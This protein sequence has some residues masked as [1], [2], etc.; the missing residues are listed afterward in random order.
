[1]SRTETSELSSVC[2][3]P[4]KA[5][6]RKG[7]LTPFI[8]FPHQTLRC[9]IKRDGAGVKWTCKKCPSVGSCQMNHRVAGFS[10][11]RLCTSNLLWEAILILLQLAVGVSNKNEPSK[12]IMKWLPT[13]ILSTRVYC[14]EEL[15]T[16]SS[17]IFWFFIS[18][19]RSYSS[20]TA[21]PSILREKYMR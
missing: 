10:W 1:M 9:Y 12:S 19:S 4:T 17:R 5:F 18:S 8:C 11:F 2:T 16:S 6:Q 3:Y 13:M 21:P 14:V 7:C 15:L 20:F